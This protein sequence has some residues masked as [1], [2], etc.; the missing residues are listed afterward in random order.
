MSGN[1]L[2]GAYFWHLEP[3][4]DILSKQNKNRQLEQGLMQS[5]VKLYFLQRNGSMLSAPSDRKGYF[6]KLYDK[7]KNASD[8]QLVLPSKLLRFLMKNSNIAI[9]MEQNR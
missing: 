8:K 1:S 3:C 2:H 6:Y 5:T 9:V 4:F 7:P